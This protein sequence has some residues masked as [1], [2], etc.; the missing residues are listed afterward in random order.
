MIFQY[1]FLFFT[2]QVD[3]LTIQ[4]NY[5]NLMHMKKAIFLSILI[6]FLCINSGYCFWI[7][8]PEN[9]RWVNPKYAPR[10]TPEDQLKFAVSLFEAKDYKKAVNE[11]G[12]L[13]KHYP[14]AK[15]TAEA[16]YYIGL[17]LE[18]TDKSYDAYI[19]YQKI[20]EKYPFSNRLEEVVEK[21]YKI[22]EK[23]MNA[24]KKKILGIELPQDTY[25]VEIFQ[26]VIKNSPYGKYASVAQ[27]KIGLILKGLA[28]F[29]EAKEE[30]EKVISDYPDTEWVEPAK[31]Q[32]ALCTK[33]TSLQAPYDQE[34]TKEARGKFEDFVKVHPDAELSK[35]A[36][37]QIGGLRDKE[38]EN[39]F[40]TGE[41]YEKQKKYESAKV[42]YNYVIKNFPK[43]KWAA[44]A[45]ERYQV[46]ERKK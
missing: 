43:T 40:M 5:G 25:V 11:F 3:W 30:F 18:N 23:L 32:A 41:F 35:D 37:A 17:S 46:I 45:F 27:Y 31:F 7:W 4:G 20:V 16:Q 10:D 39:N 6:S 14:K 12:K 8:T 24:D 1:L 29:S 2:E 36:E 38:A 33:E 28:R 15:E 19:A 44:H 42:Y 22:G 26:T 21:Q 34:M 9:K 13:I